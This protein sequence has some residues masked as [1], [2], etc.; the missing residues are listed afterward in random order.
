MGLIGG[1]LFPFY[2]GFP[3]HMISPAAF[4][5]RP[6]VWLEAMSRFHGTIS[7]APPSAYGMC[8]R[9]GPDAQAAGLDLRAWEC[10]MVGAE[11][12]S[13][14]LLARFAAAFTPV[15]FSPRAFFPVYG[16]AEATVAVTFPTL[17]APTRVDVVDRA[18]LERE[19]QAQP[20]ADCATIA[21]T[22]VGKPIPGTEIR[23]L[24]AAG[25]VAA[26]RTVGRIQVRS[27][28]LMEGYVDEPEATAAVLGDGWLS[29]GDLGY[30]AE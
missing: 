7:A 6:L 26:P 30:V 12:I 27:T 21:L 8:V 15:G 11:P 28:S 3:A 4:R 17:G 23:I 19:K 24:D 16:L 10:A 9:L 1:L 13:P 5:S 2:N 14:A 22:G 18:T 25:R 20:A 29:T